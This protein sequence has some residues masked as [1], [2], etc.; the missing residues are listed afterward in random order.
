MSFIFP[1]LGQQFP[2]F[3]GAIACFNSFYACIDCGQI[4]TE[5]MEEEHEGHEYYMIGNGEEAISF[6]NEY[7]KEPL[8]KMLEEQKERIKNRPP[9]PPI[10]YSQVKLDYGDLFGHVTP[11]VSEVEDEIPK[12]TDEIPKSEK[13]EVDTVD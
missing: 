8:K 10:D 11:R 5:C 13:K 12:A 2:L 7:L 1:G 3:Q 6:L 9:T 4:A